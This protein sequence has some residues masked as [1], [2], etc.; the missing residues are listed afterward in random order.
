[1]GEPNT[2]AKGNHAVD[3]FK[4]EQAKRNE[5]Q[6]DITFHDL[7]RSA[8]HKMRKAG[9][10]SK[11]RMYIMGHKSASMDQ[12]HTMID[13]EDFAQAVKKM[14]VHQKRN[15]LADAVKN[16]SDEKWERL[17]AARL[18]GSAKGVKSGQTGAT[19]TS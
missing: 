5:Q 12:R 11:T 14:N 18:L 19:E 3:A 4:A 7:R 15:G 16:L 8:H 2:S 6:T 17:V 9:I 13:D 1:V 10:D